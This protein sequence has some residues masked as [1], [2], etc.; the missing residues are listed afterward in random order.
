MRSGL[1]VELLSGEAQVEAEVRGDCGRG[2][3]VRCGVAERGAVPA[4]DGLVG[5]VDDDAWGVEVVGVD[6]EDF[7]AAGCLAQ[8]CGGGAAAG[9]AAVGGAGAALQDRDGGGVDPEDFVAVG[10][11]GRVF[12]DQLA[13]VGVEVFGAGGWRRGCAGR[14]VRC[15][16]D[17]FAERVVGIGR[18]C[19]AARGLDQAIACAVDAGEA[20][21][22]VGGVAGGVVRAGCGADLGEAVA[23]GV[24]GVG[25]RRGG[26][27]LGCPVGS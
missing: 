6:V 9:G 23:G 19:P 11:G 16:A 1:D 27:G 24:D 5:G 3:F 12:A 10:G 13:V 18:R 26:A 20:V 8:P 2:A 17:A 14:G 4:P 21:A 25:R 7:D 15:L 22:V